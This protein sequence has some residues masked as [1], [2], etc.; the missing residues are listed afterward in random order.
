M[1]FMQPEVLLQNWMIVEDSTGETHVVPEDC[2]DLNEFL[3]VGKTIEITK[4][5]GFGARLSAP[6]YLD[7]TE[8]S[9]HEK[10]FDAHEHLRDTYFNDWN[11]EEYPEEETYQRLARIDWDG[12]LCDE[13]AMLLFNDEDISKD[14]HHRTRM[15]IHWENEGIEQITAG[16]MVGCED[17]EMEFSNCD[18]GGCAHALPGRRT[19]VTVWYKPKEERNGERDGN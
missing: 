14:G 4:K 11:G 8:W 15:N 1:S 7:C 6:G 5:Y 2:L 13:C 3:D 18:C 10:E 16:R 17:A 12:W 19:P 9:F